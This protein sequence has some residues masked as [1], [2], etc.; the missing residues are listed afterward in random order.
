MKNSI[1]EIDFIRS[2]K[3]KDC[4]ILHLNENIPA[5]GYSNKQIIKLLKK[6]NEPINDYFKD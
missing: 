5:M 3:K 2:K 4:L 1:Y 6:Y